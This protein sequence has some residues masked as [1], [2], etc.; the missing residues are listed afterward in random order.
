[1][2][3]LFKNIR[4]F[5]LVEIIIA[6]S[7][8]SVSLIFLIVLSGQSVR[9]S[10][11]ALDT[12][13]AGALIEEGVEGVRVVRDNSWSTVSGYTV[14]TNYYLV[15]SSNTWTLN[16][17]PTVIG[18]FTRKVVFTAVKRD[19][20]DKISASGTTDTGTRLVTVTVS[21]LDHTTTVTKTVSFYIT[22]LFS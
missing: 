15:F 18:K 13:A 1:M 7:I 8:I 9:L 10:N 22:D 4:G 3:K 21:W 5:S 17:T 20:T 6:S 14:G 11:R 12:Y 2:K 19:G 16:T